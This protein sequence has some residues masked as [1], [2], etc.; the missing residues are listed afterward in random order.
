MNPRTSADLARFITEQSIRARLIAGI[1][2]TP[3]VPAAA[4]ALGVQAEQIIKTLLFLVETPNAEAP[5]A[6]VV[7]SNGAS[8]VEKALLAERFGVGKKR[9]K[10]TP[11]AVVLELLGYPAGGVPPF[12]H[13]TRLPV[14]LD[15]AITA[16]GDDALVYGGG[17][18]DRTML[19]LTVGELL[20][21]VQPEVIALSDPG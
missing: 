1:G 19:E 8:R 6:V 10:L 17:G 21:V 16:F 7:I 3:T 14:L 9:V 18:D 5:T 2:E 12:G 11:P 15:E 4:A 13:V 20:R